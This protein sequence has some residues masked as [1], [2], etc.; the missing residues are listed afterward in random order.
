MG[1][2]LVLG[3]AA[4]GSSSGGGGPQV[5]AV[6]PTLGSARGGE[7]V[8]VRGAGFQ[9]GI[10]VW[11]G[12]VEAVV[13]ERVSAGE[14]RVRTPLYRAGVVDVIVENPGGEEARLED[15]F[16]YEPL[17]LSFLEAAPH[18]LEPLASLTITDL[19]AAD[20]DGDG[21]ADLLVGASAGESRLLLGNG[22]GGFTDSADAS[23]ISVPRWDSETRRLVVRDFDGDGWPDLFACVGSGDE[24]RLYRNVAGE[25][26]EDV[27]LPLPAG[28]HGCI[29]AVAA[30]LNGDGPEDLLVAGQGPSGAG[31]HLAAYLNRADGAAVVFEPVGSLSSAGDLEGADVGAVWASLAE[32]TGSYTFTY[33]QAW[34]GET[35]GRLSYDFSTSP[36]GRLMALGAAVDVTEVPLAI[37]LELYGDN[38]NHSLYLE[39]WD[40]TGER[41]YATVLPVA[42]SGWFHVRSGDPAD[43]QHE[44]GNDDGVLDLPIAEINFGLV[45]GGGAPTTGAIFVDDI[46]VDLA[47]AGRVVLESYERPTYLHQWSD[48]PT[49]LV[50]ADLDVDGRPEV[51]V[52]AGASATGAFL[53]LLANTTPLDTP[54]ALRFLETTPPRIPLP[55]V[56]VSRIVTVDA[57]GDG[58]PD[59]VSVSPAGQD[60]LYVND[61]AG[62][63][64]DDTPRA[65]PLDSAE[66]RCLVAADLNLDG[67]PDL[68]IAN[69]NAVNRLYTGSAD[70]RFL[71]HTPALPLQS[72]ASEVVVTLDADGDGD[73]D[74]VVANGAG[75]GLRLFISVPPPALDPTP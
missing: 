58:D 11:L 40:A 21:A 57:E 19:A 60:R 28:P 71:D 46:A 69:H 37:E 54:D 64:F 45:S 63:F 17:E 1:L 22:A 65:M 61:G 72:M 30:D 43:W 74:F 68:L 9:T 36:G 10:R 53:R 5:G 8:T 4:C 75:Q 6:E 16:T 41:F 14:L 47:G 56:A 12:E 15:G 26:F 48:T 62:Y 51:I 3:V 20:F 67:R 34:Q 23:S 33:T 31:A 70:G 24:T 50:V 13:E 35:S 27:G 44:L 25:R 32:I 29:A 42:W 66:G 7:E 52:A 59:L 55:S 73:L 2:A 18:Y 49:D 39:L 38:S